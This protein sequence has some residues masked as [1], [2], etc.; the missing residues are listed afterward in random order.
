[1]VHGS[2]IS[3]YLHNINIEEKY[4]HDTWLQ[5]KIITVQVMC[6]VVKVAKAFLLNQLC[7]LTLFS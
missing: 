7:K 1:M 4:N 5:D 6:L 3:H 2:F